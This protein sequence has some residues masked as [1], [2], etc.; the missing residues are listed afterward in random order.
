MQPTITQL[1][2]MQKLHAL[3]NRFYQGGVQWIPKKGDFYTSTRAD[4][5]I[6]EILDVTEDKI[7][8]VNLTAKSSIVS[9]WDKETFLTEGFGIN[10]V[11]VPHFIFNLK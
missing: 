8:T 10:R 1:T 11:W 9:E 2:P 7:K 5:E 6:Y 3:A 4:L